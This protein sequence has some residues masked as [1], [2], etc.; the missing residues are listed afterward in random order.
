MQKSQPLSGE[1][2]GEKI[3]TGCVAARPGEARYEAKFDGVLTDTEDNRNRCG[4]SFGRERG[5]ADV[6]AHISNV[7]K[8]FEE[9]VRGMRVFY[10]ET[11]SSRTGKPE[12]RNVT[13]LDLRRRQRG[14]E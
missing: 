13:I 11:E 3:D 12:A 5:G 1:V 9:L 4:R 14:A 2:L 10:V 6:F 7:D 8:D